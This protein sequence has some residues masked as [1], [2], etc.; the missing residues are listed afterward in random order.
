M[1][2]LSESVEINAKYTISS[3]PF[4]HVFD[5]DTVPPRRVAHQHVGHRANDFSVLDNGAAAH[6]LHDTPRARQQ[7][8]VGHPDQKIL[9]LPGILI[10]FFDG[11]FI[12][13]HVAVI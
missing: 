5:V 13:A 2:F 9:G 8:V 4:H 11:D 3:F 6:A 12:F 10:D 1:K 7:N